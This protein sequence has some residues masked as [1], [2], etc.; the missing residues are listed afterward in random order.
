[1]TPAAAAGLRLG[2]SEIEGGH[3]F[4]LFDGA[5]DHYA[6]L[7]TFITEG[8]ERGERAVHII[9]PAKRD[10]HL[11]RLA[12]AGIDV[13]AAAAR[14]QLDVRTWPDFY[15][16]D[17]RF[18]PER[19]VRL[20]KDGLDEGRG[21]G[22]VAT[23]AIGFM[24]WALE[25]ALGVDAITSYEALLDVQLRTVNDVVACLRDPATRWFD[26]VF[27][28]VERTAPSPEEVIPAVFD[29]VGAWL[30][31][32]GYRGCPYLHTIAELADVDPE[33]RVRTA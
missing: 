5:D 16:V 18:E 6:P 31:R 33:N 30:E 23:R 9:D 26:R 19:T 17:G 28:G 3:V 13:D 12:A 7:M 22:Y 8:L 24:D 2:D 20:L 14:G 32:D 10:E 15:L 1:M 11:E 21:L 25:R 29:A 4:G 27:E